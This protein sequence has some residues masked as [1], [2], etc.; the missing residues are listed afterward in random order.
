MPPVSIPEVPEFQAASERTVWEALMEQLPDDVTVIAGQRIT[1]HAR[2]VEIDFLVLWPGRGIIALEVKGGTV[3]VQDG[4][5]YQADSTGKRRL[6]KTPVEQIRLAKHELSTFLKPRLSFNLGRMVHAVV[7]PYTQEP[8]RWSVPDAPR[9]LVAF[10]E[11]L[12]GM[13]RFLTTALDNQG[14]AV[15]VLSAKQVAQVV[16][17]LRATHRAVENVQL[18]SREIEDAGNLMTRE[19]EKVLSLLRFQQRAQLI[20]GAGSGKTHLA[21]MKARDQARQGL[22]VA[23]VCYSR[24]LARHFEL[25]VAGWPEEERPQ[26]VGLFH[27]LPLIL[28]AEPEPEDVG[29]EDIARY[30]DEFLP[31]RLL[32]LAGDLPDEHRFE[33]I[34][35]DESQD[36]A[37]TW[38]H[39]LTKCLLGGQEGKLFVF[40]DAHQQVFDREGDAPITL[41][42]FPLDDNLR[43]SAQ[44]A[45]CFAPL[46]PVTQVPRMEPGA[47][48]RFVPVPP[49]ASVVDMADDAV[50]SL[51]DDGWEP[52]QIA[53]LTTG[54]RHPEQVARVDDM[55]YPGYWDEFFARSD[56]F[57][58]HVLG[59][60]GLERPVVVLA[61]NDEPGDKSVQKLYVGLSRARALLV[62]VGHPQQLIEIGGDEVYRRIAG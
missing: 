54:R 5:W 25:T 50:E 3:A 30:Y 8:K 12:L 46:T 15:G 37:D 9:D 4:D 21:L 17:T 34:V 39:G 10:A 44:I 58:G 55:G 45:A 7:L 41:D 11:D 56:V 33:A 28:G 38:W 35:V 62:V 6:D 51:M 31:K 52:G 42:P 18:R 32:E 20:G 22:R 40:A 26:F 14:A 57:Y 53:L 36:F 23:L 1:D 61:M 49:D 24:G 60:K 48:V 13:E 16:K 29:R 27:D 19:Q 47:P 59:F 43:N 2:E